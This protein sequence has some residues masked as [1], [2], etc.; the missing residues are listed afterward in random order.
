VWS[1]M[2]VVVS[3]RDAEGCNSVMQ[4]IEELIS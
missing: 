1:V 3:A 4:R 2:A